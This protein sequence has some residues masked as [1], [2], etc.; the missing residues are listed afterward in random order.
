MEYGNA[1]RAS[2]Q[3]T[4]FFY[5][6]PLKTLLVI[7]G[8]LTLVVILLSIYIHKRYFDVDSFDDSEYIPVH[9]RDTASDP[10]HHDIDLKNTA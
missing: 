4:S 10:K 3:D 7:L 2:V 1:E 9:I 5:V 6:F 8:T